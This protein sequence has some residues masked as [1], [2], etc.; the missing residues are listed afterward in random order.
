MLYMNYYFNKEQF[1]K[2]FDVF[3]KYTSIALILS[4]TTL[5][6]GKL[7]T[8]SI[9]AQNEAY[10]TSSVVQHEETLPV[11][12]SEYDK[13]RLTFI[14][15]VSSYIQDSYKKNKKWSDNTATI[16]VDE[17]L[18]YNINPIVTASLI[19]AESSF[20]PKIKSYV[21]A[22]GLMQVMPFWK[23]YNRIQLHGNRMGSLEDP[24]INIMYGTAILDHYL[25]QFDGNIDKALAAYNGSRGKMKYPNKIRRHY[26]EAKS[27][28]D[29]V[30]VEMHNASFESAA[31]LTALNYSNKGLSL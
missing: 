31:T 19:G 10:Y 12:Q 13:R 22:T 14:S 15:T 1:L 21:G 26:S 20:R 16:I 24:K 8:D 9:A 2:R 7:A 27:F 30:N 6:F 4:V 29:E 18:L 17:S 25:G 28:L 11:F 3:M 23:T 5:M